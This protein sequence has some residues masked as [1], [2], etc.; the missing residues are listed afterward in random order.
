[1]HAT[2]TCTL[3]CHYV[4]CDKSTHTLSVC[5]Y[6][7]FWVSSISVCTSPFRSLCRPGQELTLSLSLS[8]KSPRLLKHSRMLATDSTATATAAAAAV[9]HQLTLCLQVHRMKYFITELNRRMI[10]AKDALKNRLHSQLY[11]Y[12]FHKNIQPKVQHRASFK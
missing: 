11:L 8:S 10:H 12:S 5:C 2:C 9:M 4:K 3:V 6:F 1:M 7:T